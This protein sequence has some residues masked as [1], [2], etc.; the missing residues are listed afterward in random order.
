MKTINT[1]PFVSMAATLCIAVAATIASWGQ[2]DDL[3]SLTK[4]KRSPIGF[5]SAVVEITDA[6]NNHQ[7]N[8]GS[9]NQVN[10]GIQKAT[11]NRLFFDMGNSLES[12]NG[13]AG[14]ELG[15]KTRLIQKYGTETGL[16][17][18][19]GNIWVGMTIEMVY[20]SIGEPCDVIVHDGSR[21]GQVQWAYR[22][23]HI[24][25]CFEDDVLI[26]IQEI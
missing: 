26:R 9:E 10:E 8:A 11:I 2:S 21:H 12:E 7:S 4:L 5:E 3:Y 14:N 1:K 18:Y 20:E 22:L 13:S 24:C 23:Y 16:E 25:L 15:R 17:L 6:G 19:N